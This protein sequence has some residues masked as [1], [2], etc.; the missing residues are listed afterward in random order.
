VFVLRRLQGANRVECAR[1]EG[2]P[3][4][5]ACA[6]RLN[7][8]APVSRFLFASFTAESGLG[9]LPRRAQTVPRGAHITASLFDIE[10]KSCRALQDALT[11]FT[12]AL[13]A[14]Y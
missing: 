5:G 14:Q 12:R 11:R 6:L 2:E 7:V 8:A 13:D 3:A 1:R 10:L 9:E 4:E